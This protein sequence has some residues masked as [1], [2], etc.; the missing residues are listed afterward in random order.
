LFVEGEC[1]DQV[2]RCVERVRVERAA[3]RRPRNILHQM[4]RF[5]EHVSYLEHPSGR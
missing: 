3:D 5:Y 2:R 1:S 4:M